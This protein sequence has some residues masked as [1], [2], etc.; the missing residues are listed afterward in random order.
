V[1]EA[2]LRAR[3]RGRGIGGGDLK[4]KDAVILASKI[5]DEVDQLHELKPGVQK[6]VA[7]LVKVRID[8][9][10]WKVGVV[11]EKDED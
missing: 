5:E 7:A 4:L 6:V 8:G 1:P 11:L 2:R 3:V 9:G 10:R